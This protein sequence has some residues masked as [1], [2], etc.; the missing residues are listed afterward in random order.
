[1]K[2]NGSGRR[3]GACVALAL[4]LALATGALA[5]CA[6]GGAHDA[7]QPPP[8]QPVSSTPALTP[9]IAADARYR[10]RVEADVAA[11]LHL[12]AATIA[13][14]LRATPGST[15]MNLAKPLGLAQ[16][17][18]GPII[19]ASLDDAAGA[20]A[21]SGNWTAAQAA[22]EQRYWTAQAPGSLITEVSAWFAGR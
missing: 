15:L 7:V 21:R 13:A 5:G 12:P 3:L 19:V 14:R 11:R 1:M 4:A 22:T 6:G 8:P 17:G 10:G 20:E 9:P 18:L 2:I 16:D